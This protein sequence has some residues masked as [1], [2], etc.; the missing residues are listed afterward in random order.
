MR[1]KFEGPSF[2]VVRFDQR[3]IVTT[4]QCA[5]DCWCDVLGIDLGYGANTCV[6]RNLPEC[7]CATVTEANCV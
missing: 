3:E 1:K 5:G 6:G 4:S 2:A 7:T